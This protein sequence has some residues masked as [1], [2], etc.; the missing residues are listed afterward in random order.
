[1]T[2]LGAMDYT[3]TPEE[4][5]RLF[6]ETAETQKKLQAQS[7]ANQLIARA[8]TQALLKELETLSA[9]FS[10]SGLGNHD[11][12]AAFETARRE[13]IERVVLSIGDSDPETAELLQEAL[14][15][16]GE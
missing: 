16:F 13:Y 14:R 9:A 11:V 2:S 7:L 4:F 15:Q 8:E 12:R 3:P 5:M 1:M 10:A 6:A